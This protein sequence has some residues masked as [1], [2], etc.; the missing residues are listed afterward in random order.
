MNLTNSKEKVVDCLCIGTSIIV[1]LEAIHQKKLGKEVLM[2]DSSDS[3]GGAWK[4]IEIDGIKDVENAIHYFTPDE[5]GINYL[6]KDLKW[7]IE[8][9]KRKY[10]YFRV[11]KNFYIRFLYDAL[12]AR[13]IRDTFFSEETKNIKD[14]IKSLFKS[15]NGIIREP[16]K[17]SYYTAEGATGIIHFLKSLLK[18]YQVE[19][20]LNS[21][22]NELYFDLHNKVVH[23]TFDTKKILCKSLILGHG[24][25]LPKIST[26]NG[27]IVLEEKFHPRPAYHLIV[28]DNIV[29]DSHEVIF[30]NDSLIKYV[31]DVTRFSSIKDNPEDKRKVFVF[32]LHS[33]VRDNVLLAEEL[34]Q[35]LK[36]I[37][38]V[39]RNA[40]IKCN[41]F[42]E[43]ILPTLYDEDLYLLK[44]AVGDLVS[45]F[46]TE[47]L[48]HGI[49]YYSD[50]WK[51]N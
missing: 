24:A 33:D 19:I 42:T 2:V 35:K 21:K 1:S 43:V 44:D 5:K 26:T 4:T 41:L 17:S 27:D 36:H 11:Y 31:H 51:T 22:I 39:G 3:F 48:T 29:T 38:L 18:N 47:N 13:L 6:K 50:R 34:L 40:V 14:V 32:A 8:N 28:E 20:E 46:R 30:T 49:G 23:C 45:I 25:R 12:S 9:S 15:I 37:K 16:R 7:P 10:Q